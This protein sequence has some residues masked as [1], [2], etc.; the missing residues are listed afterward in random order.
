VLE[1]VKS[2]CSRP[3][4]PLAVTTPSTLSTPTLLPAS[5]PVRWSTAAVELFK[6]KPPAR[7]AAQDKNYL[8]DAV[9]ARIE[10]APIQRSLVVTIAEVG[11]PT[12]GAGDV[13]ISRSGKR[14]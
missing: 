14:A 10:Q 3:A 1:I 9:T 8:F 2:N 6:P 13:Q 5:T 7:C 11:D 4:K 12:D